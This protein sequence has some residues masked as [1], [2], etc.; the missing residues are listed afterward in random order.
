MTP[1][2]LI[3]DFDGTLGDTRHTIVSTMQQT[4]A[5]LHLPP[6]SATACASTIG[7]PLAGCFES[8]YPSLP[9]ELSQR[10]ADTYRR[11]F[12]AIAHEMK[13]QPFP[14]VIATL[15]ELSRQGYTLTIASSRSHAS[16]TELT[17]AMGIADTISLVVGADDVDTAKPSPE[18]VLQTLKAMGFRA[19]ETLV[20]GDMALDIQMGA[21]AGAMTCGVTWGN[22]TRE[23]LEKA[24]AGHIINSMRE[25]Q[26]ILQH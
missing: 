2:L 11:L 5:A 16:L 23:D 26:E 1:R 12:A 9:A 4:I 17:T 19:A 20:V 3:F 21:N 13:P 15:A 6:R 7:L 24:G 10:C 14:Y 18:P 22:G 25:L 8:L